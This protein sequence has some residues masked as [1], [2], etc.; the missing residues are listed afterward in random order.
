[1][2][3]LIGVTIGSLIVIAAITVITSVLRGS[4]EVNRTQ[5]GAALGKQLADQVHVWAEADW[6][7]IANLATSSAHHYYLL[8]D[9]SPFTVAAGD[10]T[11]VLATTTYTRYFYVD[12]VSRDAGGAIV[13]SGG[14]NDPS[15]KK[16]SVVYSWPRGANIIPFY[17]TRSKSVLFRQTDWSGGAGQGGPATTTNNRFASSTNITFTTSTGSLYIN[18]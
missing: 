6:H 18:L 3:V 16:I 4:A 10:E 2:E 11:I 7:S 17:V 15:T 13:G 9:S 12:D 8:A 5:A 14:S 1:M